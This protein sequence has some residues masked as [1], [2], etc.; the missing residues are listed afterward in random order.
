MSASRDLP[1]QYHAL[2][3]RWQTNVFYMNRILKK[4]DD[5]GLGTGLST[6]EICLKSFMAMYC[7]SYV[8]LVGGVVDKINI[9][10]ARL[11]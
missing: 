6:M 9:V 11:S 8:L 5:G 1:Q 3:R 2:V 10:L 4:N 7:I